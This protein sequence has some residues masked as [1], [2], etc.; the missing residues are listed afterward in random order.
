MLHTQEA[1]KNRQVDAESFWEY[2]SV[3]S[4]REEVENQAKD[5]DAAKKP[6]P[7]IV[8]EAPADSAPAGEADSSSSAAPLPPAATAPPAVSAPAASANDGIATTADPWS[9]MPASEKKH[10][11]EVIKRNIN[12]H[13]K[14]FIE[15]RTVQGMTAAVKDCALANLSADAAGTVIFWYDVKTAGECNTRPDIRHPSHDDAAYNKVVRG[16]LAGRAA[17]QSEKTAALGA[18][19]IA[20]I[21][22]SKPGLQKSLLTP[23]RVGTSMENSRGG[24]KDGDEA[25]AAEEEGEDDQ[26]PGFCATDLLVAYCQDSI[27]NQKPRNMRNRVAGLKQ[28]LAGWL[29]IHHHHHRLHHRHHHHHD[30]HDHRHHHHHHQPPIMHVFVC[31]FLFIDICVT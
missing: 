4:R 3:V 11:E 17:E 5:D 1:I 6:V 30:H 20:L 8:N 14:F 18:G 28:Y 26:L 13:V 15:G 22:N 24:K 25:D 31:K 23:W 2:P 16:V 21:L 19:E 29:N 27:A 9:D 7:A 10:W 12:T